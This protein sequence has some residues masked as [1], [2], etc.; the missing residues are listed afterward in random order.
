LGD[1]R[2]PLQPGSDREIVQRLWHVAGVP[3]VKVEINELRIWNG[4]AE[5][6]QAETPPLPRGEQDQR[7]SESPA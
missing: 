7:Q 6:P 4:P 2:G 3:K 5:R 1:Q